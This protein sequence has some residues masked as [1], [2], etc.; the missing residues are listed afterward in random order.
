VLLVAS[1]ITF[2]AYGLRRPPA[3][4]LVTFAVAATVLG[5]LRGFLNKELGT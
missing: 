4:D 2:L 3:G 5:R 1:S